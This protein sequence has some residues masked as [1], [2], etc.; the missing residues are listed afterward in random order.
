M[1]IKCIRLQLKLVKLVL[2]QQATERSELFEDGLGS[3]DLVSQLLVGELK[4]RQSLK[5]RARHR[6]EKVPYCS[7]CTGST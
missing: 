6:P 1:K 2:D 3:G 4:S 5:S 7:V